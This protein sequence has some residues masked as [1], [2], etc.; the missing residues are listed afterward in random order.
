M[1]ESS[2]TQIKSLPLE[3][4]EQL[5]ADILD[6]KSIANLDLWISANLR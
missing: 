4:I 2:V 6:F 3:Q 1:D 5:A